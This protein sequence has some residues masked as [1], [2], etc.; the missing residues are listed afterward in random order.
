[1]Y[2]FLQS[3]LFLFL[4]VQLNE[5]LEFHEFHLSKAL[6]EYNAQDQA[7]Q[8]SMHVFLDDLEEALR[9]EGKDKLFICTTKES[10]EAEAYMETYLREHFKISVNG[11]AVTYNFLG[12]EASED[13]LAAWCYIEVE[14]VSVLNELEITND[15]L[16]EVY[17]DQKNVVQLIG[18]N[19]KR[20]TLLLQKGKTNQTVRF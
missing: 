14:N 6:V 8:V 20:G 9:R 18:P 16:L 4:P 15:L 2:L 12:K 13:L 10:A 7:I 5:G 17:D 3:L 19:R 11:Q 1:M